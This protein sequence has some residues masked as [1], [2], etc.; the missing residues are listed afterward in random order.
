MTALLGALVAV[1]RRT[2]FTDEAEQ[3]GNRRAALTAEEPETRHD[4]QNGV[5]VFANWPVPAGIR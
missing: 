1:V 3:P 5:G 4:A 2:A